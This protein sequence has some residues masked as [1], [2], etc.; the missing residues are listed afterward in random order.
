M[1]FQSLNYGDA[2]LLENTEPLNDY[3]I[4]FLRYFLMYFYDINSSLSHKIILKQQL[5][6]DVNSSSL[7]STFQILRK[8]TDDTTSLSS[9]AAPLNITT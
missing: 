2:I 6:K 8:N 3:N 4:L 1:L 7:H 5:V 9:T